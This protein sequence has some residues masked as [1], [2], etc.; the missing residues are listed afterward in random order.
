MFEGDGEDPHLTGIMATD[1]V[2]GVQDQGVLADIKH[3]VANDTEQNRNNGNAVVDERTL[4]EI[5]YP[6]FEQAVRQGHAGSIMAATS[7]LNG[8]HDNENAT[9]LTQTVKQDWGFDGFVVTDWDGAR[10]TK[11]ADQLRPLDPRRTPSIAVLGEPAG[12]APITGGGGS[13][14]VP[15]DPASVVSVVDGITQRL[16]AAGHV[17]TSTMDCMSPPSTIRCPPSAEHSSPPAEI[18]D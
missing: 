11:N 7:L 2:R 13:S 9:L 6:A 14:H 12:A 5:Y 18:L 1:Y 16:G 3:L 8:V 4:K 15:A 17:A 10:S